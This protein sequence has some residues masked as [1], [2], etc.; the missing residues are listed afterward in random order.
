MDHFLSYLQPGSQILDLGCGPGQ[1]SNYF[2]KH[3]FVVTGVDFSKEMI[4]NAR[5]LTPDADFIEANI[6]DYKFQPKQYDGVWAN[7]VLLHFTKPEIVKTLRSIHKT[8]KDKG[9]LHV[10]FMQGKGKRILKRIDRG[11]EDVRVF[12]DRSQEEVTELLSASGFESLSCQLD[13]GPHVTFI[14]FLARKE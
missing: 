13:P 7:A 11:V 2:I 6:L 8:L 12:Y 1:C 5:K 4:A 9:I 14:K 3:G 10:S